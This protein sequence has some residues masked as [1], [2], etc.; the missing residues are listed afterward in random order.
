MIELSDVVAPERQKYIE[1]WEGIPEYR[2]VSPGSDYVDRFVRLIQP[3]A[4]ASLIDIGC[5]TG[6]AGLKFRDEHRL[7]VAWLDLTDAG[8]DE[9]V[10]RDRFIEAPLWS[11]W[12]E[13]RRSW[14]PWQYGFCVDVLEHIPTEYVMLCVHRIVAACDLALIVVRLEADQFGQLVGGKLH[15]TIQPYKWWRDRIATV[16]ELRDARDLIGSGL[17]VVAPR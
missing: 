11:A 14:R 6:V 8:L 3:Q 4:G 16:G 9:Q 5:G 12:A 10:P 13:Q 7:E 15:H 17:Y 1:L 2:D